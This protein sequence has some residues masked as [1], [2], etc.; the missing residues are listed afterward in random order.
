MQDKGGVANGGQD[1]DPTAN[2]LTINVTTVNDAPAGT[3]KT[4]TTLEDT[5]YTLKVSDFGFSDVNDSP[6]NALLAV[7]VAGLPTAGSLKLNGIAVTSGQTIK[8]SDIAANK[9]IFSPVANA[10]GAGYAK[11]TFQVQDKGGVANG[12]QDLDPTANT[13]TINVTAVNDLPQGNVTI[14]GFASQGQTLSAANN[15]K[16]ADGLGAVNYTWKTDST[17]LG[18]GA[19]YVL[20]DSDVGKSLTVMASYLDKEGTTETKSS[21]ATGYVGLSKVGTAN[22]ETL[23]GS[24]FNDILTGLG[25]N[26]YLIGDDGDDRLNGGTGDDTLNGG[27]GNDLLTGGGGKDIFQLSSPTVNNVD[28]ISDFVVPDDT[29]QLNNAIFTKLSTLGILDSTAFKMG[30]AASDANDFIIYNPNTGALFYDSDGNG[31]ATAVEIAILGVN[32]ALTN[33]DFVIVGS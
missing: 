31:S 26:D 23:T 2:T 13:L 12:G 25:G 29:I 10:N 32:L 28:T 24:K 6:A 15:L 27:V 33:T 7:K 14:S 21:T 1:L 8:A 11:F 17:I 22:S 19:T 18:T 20:L 16:D 9:L 3:D 30:V 5:A 4:V